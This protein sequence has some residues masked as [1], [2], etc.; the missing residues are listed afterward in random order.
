MLKVE[1]RILRKK[2]LAC[3]NPDVKIGFLGALARVGRDYE[4]RPVRERKLV[5]RAFE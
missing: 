4:S 2:F 3:V 1:T 5:F